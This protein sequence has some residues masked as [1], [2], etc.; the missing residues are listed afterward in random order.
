MG[1]E[2]DLFNVRLKL[3]DDLMGLR[4]LNEF[5]KYSPAYIKLHSHAISKALYI[6]NNILRPNC[7]TLITVLLLT[8]MIL[9]TTQF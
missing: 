5:S 4:I 9:T 7:Q 3:T 6:T 1:L 2:Y 8:K